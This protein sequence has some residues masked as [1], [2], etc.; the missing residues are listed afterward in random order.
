MLLDT[1][2]S[3]G[4]YLQSN[5]FR[6]IVGTEK[7]LDSSVRLASFVCH[8]INVFNSVMIADFYAFTCYFYKT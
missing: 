3:S 8:P 5:Y 6:S 4:R 7:V 2:V 1:T